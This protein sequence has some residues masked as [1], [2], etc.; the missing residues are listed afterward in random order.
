[1]A[2]SLLSIILQANEQPTVGGGMS[3]KPI[4]DSASHLRQQLQVQ[5]IAPLSSWLSAY[6][7]IK[8]SV[9]ARQGMQ[10]D[11]RQFCAH[12]D[13]SRGNEA[14]VGCVS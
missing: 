12:G 8:V 5:V 13:S 2:A 14:H 1:M 10:N 4:E 9:P 3:T 6:K 7:S 11:S